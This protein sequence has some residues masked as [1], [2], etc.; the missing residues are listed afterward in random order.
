MA[1]GIPFFDSMIPKTGDFIQI[2]SIFS[3]FYNTFPYTHKRGLKDANN[4]SEVP[5]F[6]SAILKVRM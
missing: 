4:V 6:V 5:W 3:Y 2:S 1:S